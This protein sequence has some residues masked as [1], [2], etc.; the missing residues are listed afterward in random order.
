MV[1]KE[2]LILCD[3]NNMFLRALLDGIEEQGIYFKVE[4]I[5]RINFLN[6]KNIPFEMF[7]EL[8]EN[9]VSVNSKDLNKNIGF[10]YKGLTLKAAKEFGLDIGRYIK[11]IPLKGDW[12]GKY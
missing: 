12:N 2:L 3:E 6:I 7:I 1:K 5:K 11:G 10:K 8:K 9:M 4:D